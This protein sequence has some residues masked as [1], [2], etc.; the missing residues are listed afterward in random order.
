M[1][2]MIAVALCAALVLSLVPMA[3]AAVPILGKDAAVAEI[4][5][6]VEE[7][8]S[9]T[10]AVAERPAVSEQP[11]EGEDAPA[12]LAAETGYVHNFTTDGKASSFYTITGNLSTG[13]GTVTYNGLT[14]TQCLKMESSTSIKFNAPA[15][16]KLILVFAVDTATVKVDGTKLTASSKVVATE[17]AAGEHTITKADTANLFY[18]SFSGAVAEHT[19]QW[20]E[21]EITKPATC[22]EAG[23]RVAHCT[24]SGCAE[25]KT[26]TIP[27]LSHDYDANGI[28]QN[29]NWDK[30]QNKYHEHSWGEWTTNPGE[31]ATCTKEG[32]RTHTCSSCGRVETETVPKTAHTWVGDE[33]SVCHT[34][35]P[36]GTF[37]K[38]GG[39]FETAYAQW[40]FLTG[41]DQYKVYVK[42]ATENDS[43]YK[44]L[45]DQLIRR[46]PTYM[47]VD[48]VGLAAGSYVLKVEALRNNAVQATM[49]TDPITVLAHD[50]S[51]FAHFKGT[52][53]GAYNEDG[54]LKSNADVIYVT[55]AT[56]DT[57][58]WK[59]FKGIQ[60]ILAAQKKSATGPLCVRFIGN[61]TDPATL[62]KGDLETKEATNG[63]T[64]EGIGNDTVINGFGIVIKRCANMEIRN[65][66]F[67]NCDSGEGD[68]LGV[69]ADSEHI[70]AHNNDFFYGDAGSDADQAKGDGSLDT[71]STLYVTHSY[72]HFWDS[73]KCNLVGMH[74]GATALNWLTFHH[75]WYDHSDSRH[76]RV[77]GATV[78]IYNNYFDGVAKYGSGATEASNLFVENNYFRNVTKPMLTAGQGTD[79]ANS[80]KG[81]F[82]GEDGGMIKSFGNKMV[83]ENRTL[84][85]KTQKDSATEFDAY[86]AASRNETVPG[87]YKAKKGGATY[88]NF[89]T[90]SSQMY[91]YTPDSPDVAMQKVQQYAGR[92]EGGDFRWN[93]NNATED[94]NYAVI[95]DLKSELNN[96][97]G[98]LVAVGGKVPVIDGGGS[99]DPDPTP[100]THDWRWSVTTPATCEH[101][102][103]RTATCFLC[104]AINPETQTI[105]KTAHTYV[106]GVCTGCGATQGTVTDPDPVDPDP[107]ESTKTYVLTGT[108]VFSKLTPNGKDTGTTPHDLYNCAAYEVLSNQGT[109]GFFTIYAGAIGSSSGTKIDYSKKTIEGED[110]TYRINFNGGVKAKDVEHDNKPA[111]AI[112]FTTKGSA[113]VRVWWVQAG[114]DP[115]KADDPKREIAILD[116]NGDQAAVTTKGAAADKNAVVAVETLTLDKAGTY[117]LGGSP[118][119]N[120]IFKV[121]VTVTTSTTTPP[122]PVDPEPIEPDVDHSGFLEGERRDLKWYY[123]EDETLTVEQMETE[124]TALAASYDAN[125]NFL[126][127]KI[128]TPTQNKVEIDNA[129]PKLK[130][131]WLNT[132]QQPMSAAK[133]VWGDGE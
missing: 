48:A 84:T 21:W 131:F 126:G 111:D 23:E 28:C 99:T 97:K 12:A 132:A 82:S 69:D 46:Y 50:R 14:L 109:E 58:E 77:R 86:E 128:I 15:A 59:G 13:K 87:T 76:P 20:G 18:M 74:E 4:P 6:A 61:I 43:A 98:T 93:F 56:K 81:T 45:D 83:M 106:N 10:H 133:T 118:K 39:H 34:K 33:C 22:T 107:G 95:T 64:L 42:K 96:Y 67:M 5:A 44:Q 90:N 88:N 114:G 79:T 121:E 26:E 60:N 51:G 8:R 2:K 55:N 32:K 101:T 72:N 104:G 85:Y 100:C 49:V 102:G 63:I 16:G 35:K 1:S 47:R 94:A 125:G 24:Y 65:L 19:H 123:K 130:L 31:E 27:V 115:N 9:H 108:E 30:N 112:G 37:T 75:N 110:F 11:V 40:S 91:S 38:T 117:Y 80:T 54:T 66:G 119:K 71:K 52:A 7:G 68:C 116:S 127:L 73:G 89:D 70:W 122:T 57:V 25:T 105:P 78:H 129:V 113:K 120:N 36:T 17:L 92:V 29:C 62:T 124:D 103:V 41:V 53:S 3:L